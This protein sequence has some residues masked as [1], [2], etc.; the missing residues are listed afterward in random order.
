MTGRALFGLGGSTIL[1]ASSFCSVEAG[2]DAI[3]TPT[4]LIHANDDPWVPSRAYRKLGQ[5]AGVVRCLLSPRGGHVGFHG[6]N[7]PESWHNHVAAQFI[8][9]LN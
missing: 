6:Q 2:L 8:D 1:K 3:V 9:G 4:L 5:G 7:Q